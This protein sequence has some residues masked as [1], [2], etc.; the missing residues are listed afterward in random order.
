MK[1]VKILN[2]EININYS[3][4]GQD[5]FVLACLNGKLNGFFLDLGCNDPFYLSNTYLLESSFNWNGISIDIE[6]T[7]IE[8]YKTSRKCK[9]I[10]QDCTKIDYEKLLLNI[11]HI[12]YLSLDLEP[13]KT[14]LD[15][16]FSIPFNKINFSVITYEHDYYRF[17]DIYRN[18]SRKFLLNH[19]Y[20]LLCEDVKNNNFIYEDWY[21][22]PKYVDLD[23]VSV[24]KS[25]EKNFNEILFD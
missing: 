12:D 3:Q 11:N 1:K 19:G 2:N 4:S 5:L 24:F 23:K 6:N 17:G 10:C 16:L 7:F 18:E 13:A 14:T 22:N 9:A 25:K 20:Y 8:K 15:C 21:V